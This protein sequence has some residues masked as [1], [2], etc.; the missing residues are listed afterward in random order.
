MKA[1]R[2]KIWYQ[3]KYASHDLKAKNDEQAFDI[4]ADELDKK[5]VTFVYHKFRPPNRLFVT[6]EEV[7]SDVTTKVSTGEAS[8]GASMG[9]A[10]VETKHSHL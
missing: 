4:F 8:V 3:H 6:Y 10:S 1:Y 9:D 7:I 2:F 5:K